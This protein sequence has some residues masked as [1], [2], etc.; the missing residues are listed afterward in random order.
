MNRRVYLNITKTKIDSAF[1]R[2]DD[3]NNYKVCFDCLFAREISRKLGVSIEIRY[4][5]NEMGELRY[6]FSN[7][8]FGEVELGRTI[9]QMI[10]TFDYGCS[11]TPRRTSFTI[12][13]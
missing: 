9:S 1:Y 2:Q 4:H 10:K 13:S 6:T 12:K 7:E 3:F 8:E 11:I 5:V